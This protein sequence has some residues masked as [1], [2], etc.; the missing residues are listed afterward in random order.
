MPP[1]KKNQVRAIIDF[2]KQTITGKRSFAWYKIYEVMTRKDVWI[3]TEPEN[4][5]VCEKIGL[6]AFES[7]ETAFTKAIKKCGENAKVAFIP[8]GRYSVLKP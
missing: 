4:L 8:Y 5:A 7:I 6:T 3:V 2:Y 1:S